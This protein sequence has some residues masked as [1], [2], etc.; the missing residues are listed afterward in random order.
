[1]NATCLSPVWSLLWILSLSARVNPFPHS[2]KEQKIKCNAACSLSLDTHLTHTLSKVWYIYSSNRILIQFTA[3]LTLKRENW[4]Y[5]KDRKSITH[6]AI[7][8]KCLCL[9]T[10]SNSLPW[11]KCFFSPL[12]FG[13]SDPGSTGTSA[14]LADAWIDTYDLNSFFFYLVF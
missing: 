9:L 6:W 2:K 5:L 11:Q 10:K 4:K 3:E 12:A 1:M 8:T 13:T 14:L 7:M